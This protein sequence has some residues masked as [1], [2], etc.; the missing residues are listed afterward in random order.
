MKTKAIHSLGLILLLAIIPVFNS[1]DINCVD[2]VG[3]VITDTREMEEFTG[4]NIRI[5]AHVKLIVGNKNS[6]SIKAQESYVKAIATGITR[7]RL[8]VIGDVCKAENSDI[9]IIINCITLDRLKIDGSANLFSETP[10][11]VDD[12]ELDINGSGSMSLKVFTKYINNTINGSGILSLSGTSQ[13]LDCKING[14]GD[15]NALGLNTYKTKVKI[16]GSGK[17]NVVAHDNLSAT[18]RGSGDVNYSGSPEISISISGSGTV[19]KI[20]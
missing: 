13:K 9:E 10:I 12:L 17:A 20:N 19:N 7:N 2:P 11:Q 14:S 1:C 3:P 18:I 15:L 16:N 4:I 8:E 6:I 5:P